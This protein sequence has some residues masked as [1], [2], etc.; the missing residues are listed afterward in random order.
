MSTV[1]IGLLL[2]FEQLLQLLTLFVFVNLRA[3]RLNIHF[4]HS[5]DWRWAHVCRFCE[6]IWLVG[7]IK[8]VV[9]RFISNSFHHRRFVCTPSNQVPLF[10]SQ[11][12]ELSEFLVLIAWRLIGIDFFTVLTRLIH[13]CLLDFLLRSGIY[14]FFIDLN[15]LLL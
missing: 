15:R 12:M 2:L 4:F 5:Q 11:S 1:S 8:K 10:F 3:Y 13:K 9:S 14:N 6:G 7:L